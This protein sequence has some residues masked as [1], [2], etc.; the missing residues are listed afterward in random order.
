MGYVLLFTIAFGV[1]R[2]LMP[3][4]GQIN[5]EDLFK[6]ASHLFIGGLYGAAILSTVVKLR[7]RR[8]LKLLTHVSPVIHAEANAMM[9]YATYRSNQVWELAIGLTILEIAAFIIFKK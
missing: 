2:F 7:W 8:F 4:T 3:A 9:S 1:G 6:D 5:Q